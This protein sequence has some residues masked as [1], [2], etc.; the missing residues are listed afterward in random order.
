MIELMNT[1]LEQLVET[2]YFALT[3]STYYSSWISLGGRIMH[4]VVVIAAVEGIRAL[5]LQL[6]LLCCLRLLLELITTGSIGLLLC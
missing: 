6:P 3:A 2:I 5:V 4:V 1:Y